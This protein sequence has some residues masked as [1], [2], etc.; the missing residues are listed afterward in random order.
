MK[1]TDTW[2]A[3]RPRLVPVIVSV[4]ILAIAGGGFILSNNATSAGAATTTLSLTATGRTCNDTNPS[5]PICSG[6]AAGD[7][8]KVSGTGFSPG[9]L[10]S[11]VQCNSDPAQPVIFFL[12]NDI[13]VSCSPLAIVTIPSKGATK[14]DLSGTHTLTTGTVGPP[15]TGQPTTCNQVVPSTSTITACTTSTNAATDATSY[16]CPPTPAQQAAGYTCVLAIGDQAGDRAIG[17]IL[18]GTEPPPTS[19]TTSTT[20]GVTTTTTEAP[21]T[22]TAVP[23]TTTTTTGGPPTRLTGAYELYCPGTP[24]GNVVLN[25]AVTSA[26][27]SPSSP[28][29]GQAFSL[30]GYQTT[31]NLPSS[32]ASAAAAVSSTLAGSATAQIDAVGA[33]PAT[34]AV[35]PFDFNTPFPSPIP[36]AGVTLQLPST[37]ETVNGFTATSGQVVIQE[38]SAA[39]LTLSV[40]G[41]D[42]ALTCTAYPNN[43]VTPSG[44][45]TSTPTV[46]PIAP[47]IAVTG[48][49]PPVTTPG[50]ATSSLSGNGQSGGT[51][52]VPWGT[53]V[54][55]QAL[56][57]G[58]NAFRAGGTVTYAVFSLTYSPFWQPF[59]FGPPSLW[60]WQPIG[61]AGLVSVVSGSVPASLPVSLPTGIYLWQALYSGDAFNP[62][63]TSTEGLATE[64]VGSPPG[65]GGSPIGGNI[66]NGFT[67]PTY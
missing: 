33:T 66:W 5:A 21:T 51:I 64:I 8:V 49:T 55:D 44:V 9:A 36:D 67:W 6:M 23:P 47:V 2:L 56:L 50:T 1:P 11:I 17:T 35:G 34:T 58:T 52:V 3:M 15:L 28:G 46:S 53:P 18:F 25:D 26:S 40:A 39:T 37:P 12:G 41:N 27:L 48:G 62:P 10:A 7:V 16:P 13:P 20:Q 45:T 43:S 61:F 4:G 30:S 60:S 54:S 65:G 42:L 32:L 19:G 59:N 31:V 14:G 63:S 57:G 22:T 38:D 29:A 24:V